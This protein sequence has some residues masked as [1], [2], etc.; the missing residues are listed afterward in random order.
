MVDLAS[1]QVVE[2]ARGGT[3]GDFLHI[4]PDGRLY[5]TQ[6][7]QVDVFSPL[8]P[9]QIVAT[10]PVHGNQVRAPFT[11]IFITFNQSMNIVPGASGSVRNLETY[12][13]VGATSGFEVSITDSSYHADSATGA[14]LHLPRLSPFWTTM[15]SSCKRANC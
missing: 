9:P 8:T 11:E 15:P 2:V 1:L 10:N 6:T 5:L 3:R 14:G 13:L 4:G 12:T 7:N